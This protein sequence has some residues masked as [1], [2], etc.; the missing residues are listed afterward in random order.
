MR[1]GSMHRCL[2]WSPDT[3][4]RYP[5]S[6]RVKILHV[7]SNRIGAYSICEQVSLLICEGEQVHDKLEPQTRLLVM[8]FFRIRP[9]YVNMSG[10]SGKAW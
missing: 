5:S 6:K 7:E 4:E 9:A 1:H 8:V 10:A 3:L 2:L